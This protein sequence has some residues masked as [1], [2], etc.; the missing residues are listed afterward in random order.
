MANL[1]QFAHFDMRIYEG[2]QLLSCYHVVGHTNIPLI[3]QVNLIGQKFVF[4]I[5]HGIDLCIPLFTCYNLKIQLVI[6]GHLESRN[7]IT[8]LIFVC[9]MI[10]NEVI[11]TYRGVFFICIGALASPIDKFTWTSR[12]SMWFSLTTWFIIYESGSIF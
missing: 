10:E 9:D 1:F 4:G 5:K 11:S 2:A 8:N 6:V 3:F 7:G 12:S